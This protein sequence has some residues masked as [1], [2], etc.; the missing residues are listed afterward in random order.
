MPII[1]RMA[2]FFF[3]FIEIARIFMVKWFNVQKSLQRSCT[4]E[5]LDKKKKSLDKKESFQKSLFFIVDFFWQND[6]VRLG[7]RCSHQTSY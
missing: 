1:T 3:I 6:N 5:S 2:S 7:I 4:K